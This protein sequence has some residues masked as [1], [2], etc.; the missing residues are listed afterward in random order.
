MGTMTRSSS[1]LPSCR[2][3]VRV[4][5]RLRLRLRLRVWVRGSLVSFQPSSRQQQTETKMKT[6]LPTRV[7]QK[8][9]WRRWE[10]QPV[11]EPIRSESQLSLVTLQPIWEGSATFSPSATFKS[12][13]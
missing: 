7:K 5:V 9:R 11:S 10:L 1:T 3:S 2:L 13:V 6:L 8:L 12:D 4:W